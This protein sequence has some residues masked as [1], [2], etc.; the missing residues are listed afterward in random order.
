MPF[1][2]TVPSLLLSVVLSGEHCVAGLT[3]VERCSRHCGQK[4]RAGLFDIFC[5]VQPAQGN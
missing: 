3:K 4:K 2:L 5:A 1:A